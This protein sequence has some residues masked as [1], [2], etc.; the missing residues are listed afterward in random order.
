MSLT[1]HN[2]SQSGSVTLTTVSSPII[3][4]QVVQ[5]VLVDDVGG[6][7]ASLLNTLYSYTLLTDLSNSANPSAAYVSNIVDPLKGLET[8]IVNALNAKEGGNKFQAFPTS[9]FN[10][11]NGS[12]VAVRVLATIPDGFALYDTKST[13]NTFDN[14][15]FSVTQNS[16]TIAN[17]KCTGTGATSVVVPDS[18][19]TRL[20]FEKVASELPQGFVIEKKQAK[21]SSGSALG[22]ETRIAFKMIT[23][24]WFNCGVFAV[25]VYGAA[26]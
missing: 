23:N 15:P 10:Y 26:I 13:G 19:M 25:S 5:K 7:Y 9:G 17:F 24:T 20:A 3:L 16:C 1:Y 12:K 4:G 21:G 18:H 6:Y 11:Y 2:A 22:V 14:S 8:A